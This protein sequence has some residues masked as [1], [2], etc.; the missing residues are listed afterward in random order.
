MNSK[1]KNLNLDQDPASRAADR[2][3]NRNPNY[4]KNLDGK[5]P[6]SK[7]F[8]E[9]EASYDNK[10]GTKKASNHGTENNDWSANEPVERSVSES[11]EEDERWGADYI[12][13]DHS[14]YNRSNS[15]YFWNDYDV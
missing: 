7:T 9:D 10:P 6:D 4:N 2:N 15:R 11:D 14:D 13:C 1:D 3:G 5:D 8:N 12:S